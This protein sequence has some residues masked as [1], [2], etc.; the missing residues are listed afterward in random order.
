MYMGYKRRNAKLDEL[1][2]D[3]PPYLK[4]SGKPLA[5]MTFEDISNEATLR[6]VH[7]HFFKEYVLLGKVIDAR[8]L[9]HKH[10]YPLQMDYGHQ[11]FLDTLSNRRHIV[12]QALEKIERRTAEV[13]Y[14]KEKWFKWV[15]RVQE[16]DE[17]KR[18]KEQKR[19]KLEAAMFKR[20]WKK[21][22]SR[23]KAQREREEKRQQDAF[24]EEAYQERVKALSLEEYDDM[25]DPIEDIVE[26]ERGQYIDLIK[27]FLWMDLLSEEGSIAS[28]SQSNGGSDNPEKS[29]TNGTK[30]KKSKKKARANALKL[31]SRQQGS[32]GQN[33]IQI[34]GQDRVMGIVQAGNEQ[35][36]DA[37][38]PNKSNIETEPEMRKRLKEGVEKNFD[39]VEGPILVGSMQ[40]PHGS[41][42]KTAPL[43]DEEIDALTK[44]IKEIKLLLFCRLLLSHT[45]LLPAALRASGIED[46]LADPD[47]TQSD[48]R[49]LCLRVED[50]SLQDIRDACA[51]LGRG[52]ELDEEEDEESVEAEETIEDVSE[53]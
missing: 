52:D 20:H 3:S 37:A 26:D 24:L 19:V 17:A 22:Q 53:P 47:I 40:M 38:A 10:F 29:A 41:Y 21:M 9:H 30:S 48:L 15:C 32:S 49:D 23:I 6:A 46:F 44:D 50:P 8:S 39:D 28:S 18:E 42:Q 5:N 34:Q 31:V 1:T 35:A 33:Q 43:A 27:H 13:L 16:D 45:S 12:L 25:W 11:S 36:P 14:K 7:A 2:E 51:D 4:S